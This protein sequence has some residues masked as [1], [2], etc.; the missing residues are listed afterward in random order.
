MHKFVRVHACVSILGNRGHVSHGLLHLFLTPQLQD[1]INPQ[2]D[3][4]PHKTQ[5]IN[6]KNVI[7]CIDVYTMADQSADKQ[8]EYTCA[9]YTKCR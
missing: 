3:S 4:F 9:D 7:L 1:R 2:V 5:N 8:Q 6:D